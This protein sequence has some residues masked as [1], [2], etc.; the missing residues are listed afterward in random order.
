[1]PSPKTFRV[2]LVRHGLTPTTGRL[3]PGQAPGLH[4][5]DPGRRQ[6]EAVAR[7][8]A[9][10]GLAAIYTSPL[11]RARETAEPA[12]RETGLTAIIEPAL[13][14]CDF[15]EW[16]GRE[17]GALAKLREWRTVQQAPSTFRFP[18]GESFVEL[19]TRMIALMERLRTEHRGHTVA[20]F[21]HADPIKALLT[22]TLGTHL[23]HF[24][25]IDVGT[26]SVS[27]IDWPGRGAPVVRNVN[28][29]DGPLVR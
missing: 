8:L 9:D 11:E 13:L 23:D 12:E 24:Q 26:G 22:H 27:V 28:S 19:Q 25:R 4:L 15:G 2:L 6:A 7:R 17:L 16:T 10:A 29:T 14:E 20:C 21:S 18:G 1:M 5:A 3:L